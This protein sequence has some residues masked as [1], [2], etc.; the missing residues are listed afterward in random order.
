VSPADI[1]TCVGVACFALGWLAGFIA[2][3]FWRQA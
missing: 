1:V 3:R 2:G